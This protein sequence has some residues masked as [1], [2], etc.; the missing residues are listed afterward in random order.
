MKKIVTLTALFFASLS[1]FSQTATDFTATDCSGNTVNLFSELNSG[2][3]I[4]LCWVMPCGSCVGPS[5]TTMN[6]VESFS[7]SHPDAVDMYL[8]DDYANT[9][10]SVLQNWKNNSGLTGSMK[11][12]SDAAIN[13]SA[14]GTV[15]MP[16]VVVLGG[17][18]HAVFY[19]ENDVVNATD[20]QSAINA[21]LQTIGI[22]ENNGIASS[23]VVYPNPSS[24]NSTLNFSLAE[25][26]QTEIELIDMRG[27]IVK[28]IYVGKLAQGEHSIRFSTDEIK[29][30]SY[31]LR[32]STGSGSSYLDLVITN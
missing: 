29:K 21:A 27:S 3:V 30:G 23:M 13:P 2:K 17:A 6:V 18:S 9:A 14:Y 25:S 24:G 10:C 4:V 5:L 22:K 31:I 11:V 7:T 15:G 28:E 12:F 19:N 20:L 26:A 1:L 8:V 16:K 32:V